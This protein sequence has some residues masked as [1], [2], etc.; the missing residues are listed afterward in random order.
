MEKIIQIVKKYWV[1]GLGVGVFL[2]AAVQLG[3]IF[4][5]YHKSDSEYE[6]LE[7]EY[8]KINTNMEILDDEE[9][10]GDTENDIVDTEETEQSTQIQDTSASQEENEQEE[11]PGPQIPWYELASVNISAL[12]QK[13][14]DVAGWLLFE[15]VNI[16]YPILYSGDNDTYLHTTFEGERASAGSIFIEGYNTPDFNDSHTII[17]GHN[18]KNG[19]MFKTLH[20]FEESEFFQTNRY[21]FIYTPERVLVYEIYAGCQV[22]NEHLL[23]K[24]QFNESEEA[25]TKFMTDLKEAGGSNDQIWEEMHTQE[26]AP[27][28]TLS[29]CIGGKPNNRWI[30]VG[31]F[32]SEKE[33]SEMKPLEE[34][35]ETESKS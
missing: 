25:W 21:I 34:V 22:S 32:L 12:K 24:Y 1:I 33:A 14:Q 10:I 8:V 31:V 18:M 3:G 23:S 11:D 5:D 26:N 17:Y 28:V 30:V 6:N 20:N 16:S 15:N 13:N 7:E 9:Y 4:L 29:T 2:F 27:I 35:L 19:T